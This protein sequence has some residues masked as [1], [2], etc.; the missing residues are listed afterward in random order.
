M[1]INNKFDRLLPS[2]FKYKCIHPNYVLSRVIDHNRVLWYF[3]QFQFNRSI[4]IFY[5]I[6]IEQFKLANY[7]VYNY[8][9]IFRNF[10]LLLFF[11]TFDWHYTLQ[12]YLSFLLNLVL[13]LLFLC[14][15]CHI[16]IKFKSSYFSRIVLYYHAYWQLFICY[17]IFLKLRSN[18]VVNFS[19][20]SISIRFFYFPSC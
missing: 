13:L 15:K 11:F 10:I 14:S 6:L 12:L 8:L 5:G 19:I 18:I 7:W 2:S 20:D 4:F 16:S 1:D 17:T 9:S 3:P